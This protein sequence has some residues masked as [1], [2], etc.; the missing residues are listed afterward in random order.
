LAAPRVFITRVIPDAGLAKLMA[1]NLRV[2]VSPLPRLLRAEE[3]R[4]EA[5]RSD[6]VIC[7]AT[8]AIDRQVLEAGAKRCRVF[9]NCAVGYDNID[10]ACAAR[11]GMTVTHTPN[12]LT[13][14]TADLAFALLLAAARRLGDAERVLRAGA[15]RGWSMLDFLGTD[16]WGR[17]LG[18]LGAGRIGTA[19]AR[20]ARG[21]EMRLLYV[22]RDPKPAME[23][24]GASRVPLA[25]LLAE[26]DFVSIHLP[27]TDETRG[28]IGEPALSRMKPGAILINT[29]RGAI[30]DQ[31]ALIRALREGPL[32]AAGLD[33][34]AHEPNVPREL[35]A[36]ENVVLLP[37]IGSATV[38]TRSK[39]AET[40]AANVIS[41]LAG[42]G[43]LNPVPAPQE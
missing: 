36:M 1:A 5:A 21:F 33:V 28:M 16:V 30:V 31:D 10:V 41:I 3:L 37:H 35:L 42:K 2:R 39:M 6:A 25:T 24:L 27:L 29:A 20:R 14:A 13:E 22:A 7:Q 9:A 12:V 32:A 8:D 38:A 4:R 40:A 18:I 34:Y 19:V 17:T 23:S 11:L 43:P 15:W 26:S